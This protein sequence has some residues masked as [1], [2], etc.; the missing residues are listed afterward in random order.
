MIKTEYVGSVLEDLD[1]NSGT[2]KVFCAELTPAATQGSFGAAT[3]SATITMQDETG[4]SSSSESTVANHI[5]AEWYGD[6]WTSRPPIMRVAE[7]VSIFK[8]HDADKWYWLPLGRD[9]HLRQ[10]DEY[11]LEVSATTEQNSEKTDSNTYSFMVSSQ[12]RF[13]HIKTAKSLSEPYAYV[14][15]IDTAAGTVTLSDDDGQ[16]CNRIVL[17]SKDRTIHINNGEGAAVILSGKDILQYAPRDHITRADR[18]IVLDSPIITLNKSQVGTVVI[19]GAQMAIN[20]TA[21]FVVTAA[22]FGVSALSKFFGKVVTGPMRA[23]SYAAG[24]LGSA[25]AAPTSDPGHAT[26]T[27]PTNENDTDTAGEDDR[28]AASYE[29]VTAAFDATVTAIKQVASAIPTSV[30]TDQITQNANAS[31]IDTIKGP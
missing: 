5:V 9:R 26:T 23:V 28:R 19:N 7:Q 17:V 10:T 16:Y 3:T 4:V 30:S 15:R 22:R 12:G 2:I 25:Y 20:M 31:N 8:F 24:A 6:R 21:D 27:T 11:R 1:E 29:Q 13:V 18:Q 14:F